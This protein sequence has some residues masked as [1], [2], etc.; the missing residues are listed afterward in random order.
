[1]KCS[2]R[3]EKDVQRAYDAGLH[4]GINKTV[5]VVMIILALYLADKRGWKQDSI[6][7][8]L[9]Y[10]TKQSDAMSEKRVNIEEMRQALK[11]DYDIEIVW[12]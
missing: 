5:D 3:T 8:C 2:A 6:E 4:E 11:D 12:R 10:I 1:M 7:R 9:R